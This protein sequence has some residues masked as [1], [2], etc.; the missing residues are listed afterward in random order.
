LEVVGQGRQGLRQRWGRFGIDEAL[1]KAG[2]AATRSASEAAK[3]AAKVGAK[4]V[5]YITALV[6]LVATMGGFSIEVKPEPAKAHYY[7]TGPQH[8]NAE[9]AF[10]AH[11]SSKPVAK[12][13]QSCLD[14][15][16][17]ECRKKSLK[18]RSCA[19]FPSTA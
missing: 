16:G 9:V 14:W 2:E 7:G 15:I 6:S 1:E 5:G 12:G 11:V 4:S 3:K 18:R 10:V 8:G 13:L 17:V 19:G